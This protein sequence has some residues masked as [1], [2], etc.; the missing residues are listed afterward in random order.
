M[1]TAIQRKAV[2]ACARVLCAALAL[3]A[4]LAVAAQAENSGMLRV[5]LARLGSPASLT[6]KANCDY[7]LAADSTVRIPSGTEM[8]LAARNGNL[9]LT[10]GGRSVSLGASARLRRGG[11]GAAGMTF[12]SPALSNRFC[13]DLFLSASGDTIAAVLRIYI[14]DYL[15]GV[16]GNEMPPSSGIEALMAQAIVARNYALQRKAARNGSGYDLSDSGDA[17]SFRG[18]SDAP[19]YADVLRAVDETRGQVAYF[20]DSP[21]TCYFCDSNGGQTESSA[22]A[23]DAALTYSVVMDDPYDLDGAK[24][25]ATLRRDAE[26]L[27]ARLQAALEAGAADALRRQGLNADGMR[28]AAID[29]IQPEDPR[30]DAPSRLYRALAFALSIALDDGS[31]ASVTVRV[32]TYGALEQWYDLGIND[33]DNE[34]VWVDRGDQTFEITFR[35]KGSGVGM[36]QRGA[37][38]MARKGLSCETI[39][40]YYYPGV[41]LRRETL[42]DNSSD[43]AEVSAGAQPIATA[44]LKQ[45]TRLYDSADDSAA[46]RTTLPAGAGATVYAVR[47]EWAAIASG[48]LYGFIHTDALT[49]F[50][51]TGVT[52]AQV[53]SETYA[54]VSGD[55][56]NVLQLPVGSALAIETLSGGTQV[57]LNAYTDKW[58]LITTASGVEGFIPRSALT[59]QSGEALAGGGDIVAAQENLFGLLTERAGL[60]V[61]ADDSVSPQRTLEKDAQVRILAYNDTWAQVRVADGATGYVKLASLSAVQQVDT[62]EAEAVD[63]GE[64]TVVKGKEYRYVNADALSLFKSW[65][66][67]S[68]ILATLKLGEKVRLGAYNDKWA[69]VRIRDITGFVLRSG[70]SEEPPEA[71]D[72]EIEGGRITTVKGKQYAVVI[73]DNTPLY[74]SWNDADTPVTRLASGTRVQLGAYNS[75]WACVNADGVMGFMRIGTLELADDQP[76]GDSGVNYLEFDAV[77]TAD[78]ALYRRADLDGTPVADAP[79]G[80]AVHVLAYD[81]RCACVEYEGQRGFVALRYL[82]K[83]N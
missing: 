53:H 52:A 33:E 8:T 74:P 16:V 80:A 51:L 77:T 46:A 27:D 12:T 17:L 26:G 4:L 19:E 21:A 28:I 72:D 70:L 38:A 68:G 36:S 60:Y 30:F 1:R 56:V 55:T 42:S 14:E 10:V 61:N 57:R 71:A 62:P 34:T 64:I 20:G 39:L 40:D 37:M 81:E 63:G 2:N 25:T 65:S 83:A 47:G 24:K 79:K 82:K 32:P 18:Y 29:A 41:T 59:L 22:N 76:A 7:T 43:G 45:K 13:G 66:T 49:N 15:Y 23:F 73:E 44:R 50:A 48:K 58:A 69:C 3:F 9:T 78:V 11:S 5:K 6:M 54:R 75:A 31:V 35:R 67:E